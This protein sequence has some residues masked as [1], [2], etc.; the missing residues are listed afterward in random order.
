MILPL[1][2][3]PLVDQC[4]EIHP[5]IPFDPAVPCD[6]WPSIFK[7]ICARLESQINHVRFKG[8]C[9]QM[10]FLR[11]LLMSSANSL[12]HSKLKCPHYAILKFPS[13]VLESPT[14]GLHASKVKKLFNFL[15]IDP[16]SVG[17]HGD[18]FL[19]EELRW[20]QNDPSGRFTKAS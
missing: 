6:P 7:S 12:S 10:H 2:F 11:V 15:I 3:P 9:L 14:T 4:T 20:R 19:R 13:V 1:C 8:T 17:K 16:F 18:V 5:L